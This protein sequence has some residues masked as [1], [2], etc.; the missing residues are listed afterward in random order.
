MKSLQSSLKETIAG[1]VILSL[2]MYGM[3]LMFEPAV[4]LTQSSEQF[5]VSLTVTEE[6][7][8]T[9][10]PQNVT[11]LPSLS[12]LTGGTADGQ[13]QV[14]VRTNNVDG[15]NMT[16][17]GS[18]SV[19]FG[20]STPMIGHTQ[21]D[22][23][24]AVTASG[25]EPTY[26]FRTSTVPSQGTAFGYSIAAS[27]SAEIDQSFRHDVA[28]GPNGQ[29]DCNSGSFE[30]D[31]QCWMYASTSAFTVYNRASA[32]PASGATTTIFFRAIIQPN[33]SPAIDEDTY[34]ATTTLTATA[35]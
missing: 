14:I 5:E 27:T 26:Q 28:D 12:G 32:T 31:Q 16:L 22:A 15:F 30:T 11:L 7:T 1:A 6:L 33:P 17:T 34:T 21:G 24:V 35:N 13:T 19:P 18:S 25:T 29:Q 3:F 20:S 4:G 2:L 9:S 10:Q 23:I 8:F